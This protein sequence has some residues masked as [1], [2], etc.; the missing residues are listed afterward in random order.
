[1]VVDL[2]AGKRPTICVSCVSI[3]SQ[4]PD[5]CLTA[6]KTHDPSFLATGL[7]DSFKI[8]TQILAQCII[9]SRTPDKSLLT[10]PHQSLLAT[11]VV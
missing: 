5:E 8:P 6:S 7:P 11:T 3:L 4:I 1:M 10:T 9:A 2:H